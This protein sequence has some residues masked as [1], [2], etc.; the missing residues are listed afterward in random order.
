MRLDLDI[1]HIVE[2]YLIL[3]HCPL[4]EHVGGDVL[5]R[6]IDALCP[7]LV[8]HVGKQ[9]HLELEAKYIHLGDMLLAALQNDLLN[10]QPRYWQIYWPDGY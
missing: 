10:E 3:F 5:G 6:D 8:Q 1:R 9:P 4:V 2:H 7:S